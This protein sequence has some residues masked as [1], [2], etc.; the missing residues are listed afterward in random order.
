MEAAKVFYGK[1]QNNEETVNRNRSLIVQYLQR[2]TICTRAQLSKE[3]D[4]TPASISKTISVLIESGVVEETGYIPGEKGRRSVGIR[5]NTD[6]YRIIGA[7][8]SRRSFSIGVFDF[9]GEQ[10]DSNSQSFDENE[11]LLNTIANIQKTIKSYLDKYHNVVAVGI[12]VP[13]PFLEQDGKI[14]LITEMNNWQV[15][16]IIKEFEDK[17]DVPVIIRHDAN[18]GALAEWWFG[19]Q[20]QHPNGTLIHF[21]VGEGVGAGIIINGNILSGDRGT[22]GEVGHISVDVEGEKCSCGNKGCL[23]RYCSSIAFVKHAKKQLKDNPQSQLNFYSNLTASMIFQAAFQGDE[24]AIRLVKRVGRYIGYGV[25]NLINA[26]DP[27]TIVISNEMSGGGEILLNE[28]ISVVKERIHKEIFEK[29][30]IELSMFPNDPI[31]YGAAAIAI[32]YCL[33]NPNILLKN[34][35]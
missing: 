4:L 1:G 28:V 8:L 18:S 14:L 12:A 35:N 6:S 16:D 3:L 32:D 9:K 17:F 30:N 15:I 10:F 19:S 23:E 5:L 34:G 13:G 21:L 22:A 11:N 26:Y 31:L 24:L 20:M 29:I 2:N 7:R 25:I 33:K 27:S